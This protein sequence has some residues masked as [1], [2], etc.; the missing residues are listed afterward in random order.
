ME[1][2]KEGYKGLNEITFMNYVYVFEIKGCVCRFH[3][4]CECLVY[5]EQ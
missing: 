3:L 1:H 4:Y 2:D 5:R